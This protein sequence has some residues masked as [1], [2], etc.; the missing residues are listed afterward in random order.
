MYDEQRIRSP[1]EYNCEYDPQ[2]PV[3]NE[4]GDAR[5]ERDAGHGADEQKEEDPR[6]DVSHPQMRDA[7]QKREWDGVNDVGADETAGRQRRI[8]DGQ[9]DDTGDHSYHNRAQGNQCRQADNALSYKV[10]CAED[11]GPHSFDDGEK[12][13]QAHSIANAALGD[14]LTE[15]HDEDG[16]GR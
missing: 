10:E 5:A 9:S 3:R 15:P 4:A 16:T 7:R 12:D 2:E 8:K 6:I 14:L 13:E 1:D 11:P